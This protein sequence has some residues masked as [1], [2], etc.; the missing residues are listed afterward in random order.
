[1]DLKKIKLNY[2]GNIFVYLLLCSKIPD[3]SLHWTHIGQASSQSPQCAVQDKCTYSP[4]QAKSS[5]QTESVHHLGESARGEGS[6]WLS[7]PLTSLWMLCSSF[8]ESFKEVLGD[9]PL[10]LDPPVLWLLWCSGGGLVSLLPGLEDSEPG[11]RLPCSPVAS[12]L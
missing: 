11:F 4:L 8:T 3:I 10:P 9:A 1:M 2:M 5:S 6:R 12:R 7:R